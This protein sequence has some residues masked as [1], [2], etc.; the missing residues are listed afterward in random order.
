LQE[1]ALVGLLRFAEDHAPNL[2]ASLQAPIVWHP[3]QNLQI[4]NSALTQL[5]LLRTQSDQLC[6]HDLFAVP[7][8]AMGKRSLFA[9]LC[10]PIADTE[11]INQRQ[12]EIYWINEMTK[13][14]QKELETAL[15]LLYDVARLHRSIIRGTCKAS[16]I[17]QLHQSYQSSKY[18]WDILQKSPFLYDA[19]LQELIQTCITH[20]VEFF[21]VEKA[22]C[23]EQKEKQEELGFLQGSIAPKTLDAEV[24]CEAIYSEAEEWLSTLRQVAGITKE[25]CYYKPT[26]KNMFSIHCTK[27]A[28]TSFQQLNKRT[29]T[30]HPAYANLVCKSLTS[31]GRLEHPS[32]EIFQQKLDSARSNFQRMLAQELPH[33]CI[34]YTNATGHTWASI[35]TWIIQVDLA[36]TMARTATQQGWVRPTIEPCSSTDFS[37]VQLTQL[38]HPL[39][40]AQKRQS[41]YVCHDVELGYESK[42]GMLLYG[43]N[44]SGKSSLMKAIGLAVLLAQVGSYVPA[45]KM[46]LRPYRK[47]ATRILNQDNLW[48]GL[49]SF[50]VEMSELRDIFMIADHQTLV[51]GDE[52]C[53]GTESISATAIVAAGIQHLQKA[54]AQFVLATHLHDLMKLDQIRTLQ[55]LSIYHL[56]VEY[57]R[58]RDLLVYHRTLQPG[59]GSTLYGLEV[60]KAL[61][62]PIDMIEAAFQIRRTL[63]GEVATEEAVKSNWSSNLIL[64][65]CDRCGSKAAKTL[66][67]HHLEQQKDATKGRNKDGQ[68]LHHMRNLA[69]LCEMCHTEHHAGLVAIGPVEDTSEGPIRSIVELSKYAYVPKETPNQKKSLFTK[70]QIEAIKQ[71]KQAHPGVHAKLLVLKIKKDYEI[72]ITEAQYKSLQIKGLI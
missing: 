45:T 44:A 21:D 64:Q 58:V 51:L 46:V 33:A 49:S 43:M 7:H 69:T 26:D 50:A 53:A 67:T 18:L 61:H 68:A 27:T 54:G 17:V 28:L 63:L 48:A 70:E 42:Q 11:Q 6:I 31:A 2:A 55:G 65:T 10:S 39:I 62:L 56:H 5:N 30:Q 19:N 12:E 72:T 40:E 37:R 57:D 47:L 3:S 59:S 32:L 8:T 71:V 9:R 66:E 36:F 34:A 41:K 23:V 25:N 38:R 22:T 4:I 20:F 16:D 14:Q 1:R 60:A 15:S 35:E 52:L 13:Q 29:G 24:K